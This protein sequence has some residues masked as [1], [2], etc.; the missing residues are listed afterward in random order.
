MTN[1]VKRRGH[2]EKF[3]EKKVYGSVYAACASAHYPEGKCEKIADQITKKVKKFVASKKAVTSEDLRNK[4]E[5]ELKKKDK[6]L[7]FYYEQH[8]PDLKK[9]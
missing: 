6:E 7:C 2:K 3:D 1:I 5:S 8:L 9:L 4:I